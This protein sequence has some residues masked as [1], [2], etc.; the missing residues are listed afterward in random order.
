MRVN[1]ECLEYL[2]YTKLTK[3]Q[4][5]YYKAILSK[6]RAALGKKNKRS[7]VN[8]IMSLRKCCNHP[9]MFAGI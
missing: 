7:L 1:V 2:L 4:K 9:Y 8:V 6:D 3:M 5:K